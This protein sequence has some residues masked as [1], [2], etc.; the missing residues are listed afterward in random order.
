MWKIVLK[1][2]DGSSVKLTNSAGALTIDI[3]E[4][5][6]KRYGNG[7]ISKTVFLY[8]LKD[9]TPM[10]LEDYIKKQKEGVAYE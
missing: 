10:G 7:C 4:K 9:N 6:N 1:K 5:Y 3:A 8:P 2:K